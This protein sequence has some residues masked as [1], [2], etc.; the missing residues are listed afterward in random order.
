MSIRYYVS[1]VL[2]PDPPLPPDAPEDAVR[3]DYYRLALDDARPRPA[4]SAH[5]PTLPTGAPAFAWGIAYAKATDWSGVEA[6]ARNF[7]LFAGV[8]DKATV[9]EIIADLSRLQWKDIPVARRTAIRAKAE[10]LGISVNDISTTTSLRFVL[11]KLG[12]FLHAAFD[13]TRLFVDNGQ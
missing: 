1:A 12:T 9:A 13:E 4:F 3:K 5:I 2:P 6:D 7:R 10:A 8:D 11:R